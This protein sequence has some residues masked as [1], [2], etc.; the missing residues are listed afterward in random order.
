MPTLEAILGPGGAD[1][2]VTAD[3]AQD[4]ERAA[5]FAAKA[6]EKTTVTLGSEKLSS[7]HPFGRQ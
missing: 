4:K 6:A 5:T 3:T 7:G 1:M 2:V